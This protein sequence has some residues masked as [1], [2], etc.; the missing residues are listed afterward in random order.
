M[1]IKLIKMNNLFIVFNCAFFLLCINK[2]NSLECYVCSNQ[3]DNKDKCVETVKNCDVGQDRC[4]SQIRWGSTPYWAPSGE[5]Q[6]YITKK[7]ASKEICDQQYKKHLSRCDRIWYNDWECVECCTG[8]RCNYYVTL[9][10]SST[11]PNI[12]IVAISAFVALTLF[13]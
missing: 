8:D 13:K 6:Y 4:L 9:K 2:V 11:Y 10:S 1:E 12:F 7:C 3:E 5:K